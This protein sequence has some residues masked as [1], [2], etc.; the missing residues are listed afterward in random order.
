MKK[1]ITC[2]KRNDYISFTIVRKRTSHPGERGCKTQCD[3][4]GENQ[5]PVLTPVLCRAQLQWHREG[6]CLLR[7]QSHSRKSV[8]KAMAKCITQ[9]LDVNSQ[10]SRI[11]GNYTIVSRCAKKEINRSP[12]REGMILFPSRS[13]ANA[14]R[15]FGCKNQCDNDGE[16]LIPVIT[17]LLCRTSRC[18]LE[19]HD[20]VRPKVTCIKV[21][22][23]CS[24]CGLSKNT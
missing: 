13:F 8:A 9:K 6:G 19:G 24:P 7:R 21:A 1:S 20:V 17:L 4:D 14:T 16:T 10:A 5:I 23:D 18:Q 15:I 11:C 2:R 12:V 22:S 3:N